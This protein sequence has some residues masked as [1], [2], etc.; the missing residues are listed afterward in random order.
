MDFNTTHARHDPA[1]CLAPGLFRSLKRG[2]RKQMKLDVTYQYADNEQARFIGFEPLGADD[3]RLLQGLVALSGPKGII[4]TPSPKADIFDAATQDALVVQESLTR[5]LSEIGL[6]AG[7]DNL[8]GIKASLVRMSNV[9]VIV[10]KDGKQASFHLMS[11]ALDEADGRLFVA[12]NPRITEAILGRRAYTWIDMAEVRGL[13]SDPARFMHQRLCG[14]INTGKA[15]RVALDTL[16]GYVWPNE[17]NENAMRKRRSVARKALN[18]LAA[19]GWTIKEYAKDKWEIS[20]PNL[21]PRDL[22]REDSEGWTP[23]V[24]FPKPRSNGNKSRSNGSKST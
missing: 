9:T 23:T 10:T 12:L 3:M 1:H 5:L 7:G 14:W 20:R 16:C 8:K 17:I 6:T 2:D 22:Y 13:E 19:L 15:G 18:E 21:N 4:L 24:T 11:H